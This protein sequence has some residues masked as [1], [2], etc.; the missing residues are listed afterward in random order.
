MEALGLN[1]PKLIY[2]IINFVLLMVILY[3]LLYQRV[4]AMLAERRQRIEQ[5]LKDAEQVKLQ[6]ANA[7]RDYDAEIAKA[8][9]EAATIVAQAQERARAQEAEIVAQARREA[10]R[11]RDEAR[12]QA[13][14]EREQLLREAKD[15][16]AELVT[17]T[18]SRV[19]DA[20]LKASGHDK[21]IAESLSALGRRN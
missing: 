2:Q 12:T 8:R 3:A 17:L 21:L 15:Q 9:Q 18:A 4:L 20:E 6:L 13:V 7:R 16:I 10:E 14:Q 1:L 11:V 19:L 5:S